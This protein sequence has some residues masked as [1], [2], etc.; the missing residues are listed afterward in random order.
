MFRLNINLKRCIAQRENLYIRKRAPL[1]ATLV[2]DILES[3]EAIEYTNV[4]ICMGRPFCY[5]LLLCFVP[6]E[7]HMSV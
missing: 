1:N 6:T 5:F 7:D 4:S 3:K 2:R